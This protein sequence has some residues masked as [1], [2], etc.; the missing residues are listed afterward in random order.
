MKTLQEKMNDLRVE[1]ESSEEIDPDLKKVFQEVE[2]AIIQGTQEQ[3]VVDNTLRR[4]TV[5]ITG[6]S[7]YY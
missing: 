1:I 7:A 4:T 5:G 6:K 3:Q 2:G